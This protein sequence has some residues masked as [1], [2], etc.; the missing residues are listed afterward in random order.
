LDKMD[1]LVSAFIA[2]GFL[3]LLV[4]ILYLLDRVNALEQKT[5][6]LSQPVSVRQEAPVS[7]PFFG[8]SSK[9]LWDAMSGRVPEG[10]DPSMLQEIRGGYEEVLQKHLQSLFQE[11]LK[12]G[13]RGMLGEPKNNRMIGSLRGQIESWLPTAQVNTVYKCGLDCAQLPPE[14]WGPLRMALDEAGQ[15]LYAKVQIELPKPLSESLIPNEPIS[16]VS[17]PMVPLS[18][19]VSPPL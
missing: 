1:A 4:F 7:G 10:M 8:L 12:D 19:P 15:S 16:A 17:T 18:A 6:Q 3:V 9:K 14:Q 13:Q 2:I 5:R 11:G